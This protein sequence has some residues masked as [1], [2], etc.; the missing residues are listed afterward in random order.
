[1]KPYIYDKPHKTQNVLG[2]KGVMSCLIHVPAWNGREIRSAVYGCVPKQ[3]TSRFYSSNQPRKGPVKGEIPKTF[4]VL[5]L[6]RKR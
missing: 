5:W 1:M 4:M 2:I 6:D 3:R